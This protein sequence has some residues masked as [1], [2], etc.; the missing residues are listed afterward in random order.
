MERWKPILGYEGHYE[1]SDHGHVKSLARTTPRG[2]VREECIMR[3]NDVRG[4]KVVHLHLNGKRTDRYVHRLVLAAFTGPAGKL[5][6]LHRNGDPADNRLEN[7]YYGTVKDNMADRA[8]HGNSNM[9]TWIG[10]SHPRAVV[11]EADVRAIKAWPR[12]KHGIYK[13]FPHI[14]VSTIDS[15]RS[16]HTWKHV[17]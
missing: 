7:L 3:P 4:Y 5:H 11:T 2:E 13:A 1:V 16:R 8:R 9:T 6:G 14:K 12:C 17:E 10:E 15:I